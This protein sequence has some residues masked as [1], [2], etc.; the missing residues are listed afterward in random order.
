MQIHGS[1]GWVSW[2]AGHWHDASPCQQKRKA[3]DVDA[4][5]GAAAAKEAILSPPTV[6]DLCSPDGE[7]DPLCAIS[8]VGQ[9]V[10][11]PVWGVAFAPLWCSPDTCDESITSELS[12]GVGTETAMRRALLRVRQ[13][14]CFRSRAIPISLWASPRRVPLPHVPTTRW[15]C[16]GPDSDDTNGST[17]SSPRSV[18]EFWF[19]EEWY[20][21]GDGMDVPEYLQTNSKRWF[22]G[23]QVMDTQAERFIPLIRGAS[24]GGLRGAEWGTVD[25][26][27]AQLLLFDQLS[28]NAF[29]GTSEAFE[30]DAEAVGAASKL[31]GLVSRPSDLPWPAALFVGTCLMHSEDISRHHAARTFLQAHIAV[32]GNTILESQMQTD[33]Q[34]HTD[35][36]QR[37][38]RY[39]HRNVLHS[40]ET[41]PEERAW[42][43]SDDCPGWAKSQSLPSTG[44]G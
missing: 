41:T 43:D 29:R 17:Y 39:P 14:G 19:G 6:V 25:G 1:A 21:G 15:L 9:A 31:L 13:K 38:G 44:A 26:L 22:M 12:C 7:T 42:L 18:L 3:S 2:P 5:Y 40:R 30:Y 16:G 24:T 20:G 32:S 27:V 10:S 33:L 28:R 11:A 8:A 36:I 23:G 37:F 4:G 35:V 34:S